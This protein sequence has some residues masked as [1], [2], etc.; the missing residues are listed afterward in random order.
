[1]TWK[2]VFTALVT[3]FR[4]G[5]VDLEAFRSHCE[6]QVAA[7]IDGLVPCGTTGETPTLSDEEWASLVRIAVEAAK[8]RV[9]VVAG[10]GTNDTAASVARCRAARLLGADAAL[11]VFPYYNKPPPDGLRAHVRACASGGLPLVLYHVPGRTGQRLAPALLA[12]LSGFEGVVAVKEATGDME[13]ANDLLPA[14]RTPMLSGDDATILPFCV[15]GGTG[16]I[17]VLSNVAPRGTV[18]LLRAIDAGDLATARTL[19]FRYLPL[20]RWLFHTT[21]PAPCKALMA[22]AG[23]CSNELRLPLVPLS[24][25]VPQAI[26]SLLEVE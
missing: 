17:S 22:S 13:Y 25:P 18:A 16:V 7:G 9:P 14:T 8:G 2:G 12:E 3:P 21:S 15:L 6:R 20:V 4:E 5:R 11:V 26:A 1:M 23:W 10:C 19:H 24:T